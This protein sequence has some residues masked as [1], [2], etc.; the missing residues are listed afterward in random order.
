M[1][2]HNNRLSFKG[3]VQNLISISGKDISF[4]YISVKY[5]YHRHANCC[6]CYYIIRNSKF[7]QQQYF[8]ELLRCYWEHSTFCSSGLQCRR[9]SGF[10]L[11]F[12]RRISRKYLRKCAVPHKTVDISQMKG[13]WPVAFA[14]WLLSN[15]SFRF[16]DF[17]IILML[18]I[19]KVK[20][21]NKQ[22]VE[23]FQMLKIKSTSQNLYVW[24][25][26]FN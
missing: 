18:F 15:L 7:S 4:Y 2:F 19:A 12:I 3:Y 16:Y 24:N 9:P 17:K 20:R 8:W 25:W 6:L 14:A 22:K 13:R 5:Y 10:S 26:I 21:D 11:Q 1:L 23:W